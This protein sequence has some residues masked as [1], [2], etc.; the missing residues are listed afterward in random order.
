MQPA[1]VAQGHRTV[2]VDLVVT[3]P[4]LA[5]V[6]ASGAT[7][8]SEPSAGFWILRKWGSSGDRVTHFPSIN[9]PGSI[10]IAT[11]FRVDRLF[12]WRSCRCRQRL[13]VG[14]GRHPS[15][16][17][18][19]L[20]SAADSANAGVDLSPSS[21]PRRVRS[22]TKPLSHCDG[23]SGSSHETTKN[24]TFERSFPGLGRGCSAEYD[25]SQ[26]VCFLSRSA[27]RCRGWE[28]VFRSPSLWQAWGL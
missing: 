17:Q 4:Q 1:P 10:V 3:H 2:L 5:A 28:A 24:P 15:Q 16:A 11:P 21:R 19:S 12:Q 14:S 18:D 23:L 7:R 20:P 6:V 9:I 8:S 25:P 27:C 26:G 13:V 22:L